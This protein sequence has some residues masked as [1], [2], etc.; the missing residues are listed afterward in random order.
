MRR[1]LIA[2]ILLANSVLL[3]GQETN[4]QPAKT[5]SSPRP[6]VTA[7]GAKPKLTEQ[8]KRGLR[9]L[10]SAEASAGGFESA[11][12]IVAYAQIAR[13]YQTNNKKK[14]VE[15]LQQAY[16]S[17]RTLQLDSADK[18]L[19][20][21]VEHQL[22][23][24]VLNQYVSIAPER[25][26]ALMDEMEPALRVDAMRM[27]LPYYEKN[28]NLDRA[29]SM[30]LQLAVQG[31][32]PYSTVNDVIDKLGAAHPDAIRQLFFASVASYQR[33]QHSEVNGSTDFASLISKAYGKVPD[34]SVE[35]AIDELL[36]QAKKADEEN[37]GV[38]V[39]LGFDKGAVQFKSSY[40]MQLFA[41]LPTL[42]QVD[43]EKAKRLLKESEDVNTFASKY[44]D[45]MSSLSKTGR[46][47]SVSTHTGANGAGDGE[48]A[49]L[50]EEQQMNAVM[51]DATD[52]PNDALANAA[53][54]SPRY[55]LSAYM[56]IARANFKKSSTVAEAA[57]G[58]AQDLLSKVPVWQ[59]MQTVG[60][61]I[62][63]YVLLG[64]KE[65]AQKAIELATKTA[66]LLYKQE[67]EADDPN[68]APKAWWMSTNA[69]R[70]LVDAS[71][72]LDP[73]QAG[74]LLKEAPDD[75]VRIFAQIVLAKRMLGNTSPAL[76]VSMSASKKGLM[77]SM[78]TTSTPEKEEVDTHELR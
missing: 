72:E 27:L 66:G 52:H 59:Q 31:E 42:E 19:N 34:D 73:G 21:M 5:T 55:A 44:P 77:M 56:G 54:L 68:L 15:L 17:V 23:Q 67:A 75:E 48:S 46:P 35:T 50:L 9:L 25:V 36:S 38:T 40:D 28:K 22:Q 1:A 18:N 8:Q 37:K 49:H 24:Q 16:E 39:S 53:G 12:R 62:N 61:I 45:G 20:G 7:P 2:F 70:N 74:T 60:E 63:L 58:K 26:D 51:R 47:N 43:P 4:V 71:Y 6:S 13:V 30:L 3:V 33:R 78:M 29:V 41:V 11:S 69:W 65:S 14:S 57:L 76:D 10:E 64:D 32:M